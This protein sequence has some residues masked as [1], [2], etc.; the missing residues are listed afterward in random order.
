L[1]GLLDLPDVAISAARLW[2]VGQ[3]DFQ[4]YRDLSRILREKTLHPAK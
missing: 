1:N 2:A 4:Y 3:A